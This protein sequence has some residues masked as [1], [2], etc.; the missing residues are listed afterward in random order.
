MMTPT[1]RTVQRLRA[2]LA[3]PV[4]GLALLAGSPL[5]AEGP[6]APPAPPNIVLLQS[7]DWGWPFYGFMQRYLREK[8]DRRCAATGNPCG[9]LVP[10]H[11]DCA[12]L[13]CSANGRVER[14]CSADNTPCTTSADCGGGACV[15]VDALLAGSIPSTLLPEYMDPELILPDDNCGLPDRCAGCSVCVGGSKE[16]RLCVLPADCP[17]GSCTARAECTPPVHKL[18]TPALDRLA[19]EGNYF[20]LAHTGASL[21]RPGLVTIMTGLAI[22]DQVLNP[23]D[24]TTSPIIPEWLPGFSAT[25]FAS[26]S[27][28]ITMCAGKCQYGEPHVDEVAPRVFAKKH[29]FDRDMP[30]VDNAGDATHRAI[31]EAYDRS[32]PDAAGRAGLALERVKDFISCAACVRTCQG[33]TRYG[34]PC[35]GNGDCPGGRCLPPTRHPAPAQPCGSATAPCSA[36][37]DPGLPPL[38]ARRDPESPRLRARDAGACTPN[39]FYVTVA[40]YMPHVLYNPDAY[41][42]YFPRD[43]AQC[44]MEPWRSH[45]VYC[46]FDP[47]LDADGIDAGDDGRPDADGD[48]PTCDYVARKLERIA[49]NVAA[50][51]RTRDAA[52]Y[53]IGRRGFL[54]F[55]N[56]FDRVA[57]ELVAHL[58]CPVRIPDPTPGPDTP[59]DGLVCDDS[60]NLMGNTAILYTTDNGFGLDGGKGQ[61]KEDG[62]RSPII[63][64]GPPSVVAPLPPS[65]GPN[66]PGCRNDFA[67]SVDILATITDLAGT[68]TTQCPPPGHPTCLDGTPGALGCCPPPRGEPPVSRY[69]EGRSLVTAGNRACEYPS[70]PAGYRQCLIGSRQVGGQQLAPGNGW[71]VLAEVEEPSTKVIHLCKLYRR[72]SACA[73]QDLFDLRFD[74]NESRNLHDE[75]APLCVGGANEGKR[76][77]DSL[78]CIGGLCDYCTWQER[79]LERILRYNVK[80]NGW[81]TCADGQWPER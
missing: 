81:L 22:G 62:H 46:R 9:R 8:V 33:G 23:T 34:T 35:T 63:L 36:C 72:G 76:C 1:H 65:C 69:S 68:S 26:P 41:C 27:T 54:R 37:S 39:P 7:D 4:L 29:A 44:A 5:S 11:P 80:Q 75:P 55:I 67:H 25:S 50:E 59:P 66:L 42:P 32:N 20:P 2:V 77:M 49:L 18:L 21:C 47:A 73:D 43:A 3:P 52:T 45:S 71:Y 58:G 56:V 78:D 28:Y 48:Y 17:G 13:E 12:G 70:M 31:V 40:P 38:N 6:P 30:D 16:G 61:F 51:R 10:E 60:Q 15:T 57:D 64:H 19:E 24:H 53:T 79:D 14:R 74:P